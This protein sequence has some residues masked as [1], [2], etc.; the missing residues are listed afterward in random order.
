MRLLMSTLAWC[1]DMSHL[2]PSHKTTKISRT[3]KQIPLLISRWPPGN[4]KRSTGKNR[5]Q[6]LA[7]D[8]IRKTVPC[9]SLSDP[10]LL[11]RDNM[12]RDETTWEDQSIQA[13]KWQ[14]MGSANLC[15]SKEN[16]QCSH[17]HWFL[18]AQQGHEMETI[19]ATKNIWPTKTPRV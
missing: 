12:Q 15:G 8:A 9:E 3:P 6:A 13:C 11:Q 1:R 14:W 19:S 16:R 2:K 5:N 4:L 17:P 18:W 10:T 7:L